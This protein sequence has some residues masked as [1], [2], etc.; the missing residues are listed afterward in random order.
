L[1][2]SRRWHGRSASWRRRAIKQH[3]TEIGDVYKNPVIAIEK[4]TQ[5]HNDLIAALD[6]ADRLKAEGIVSARE[7]IARL[8]TL[9]EQ[10]EE[11][12]HGLPDRQDA[13][14]LEA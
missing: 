14:M 12:V 1:R 11:K 3:T 6:T 10:L 5:A 7:N 2:S 9:S 8:R 13:P 4:L